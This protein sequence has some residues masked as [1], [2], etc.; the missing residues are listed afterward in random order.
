M[1]VAEVHDELQLDGGEAVEGHVGTSATTVIR[2]GVP[3][4][5]L[6]NL[7]GASIK[8]ASQTKA[9]EH[10]FQIAEEQQMADDPRQPAIHPGETFEAES[11]RRRS[12]MRAA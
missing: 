8:I 3:G 4:G 12:R 5:A 2:R 10:Q 9:N 11:A 1:C 7:R 6:R